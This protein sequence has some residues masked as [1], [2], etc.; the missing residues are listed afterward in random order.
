M[1]PP[2]R[3]RHG[4]TVD[5]EAPQRSQNPPGVTTAL[6]LTTPV[7]SRP[8]EPWPVISYQRP[9]ESVRGV[10][11]RRPTRSSRR[12]PRALPGARCR[13]P[14]HAAADVLLCALHVSPVPALEGVEPRQFVLNDLPLL[15][16]LGYRAQELGDLAATGD[17]HR[18]SLELLG[19]LRHTPPQPC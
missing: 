19:H 18:Q 12:I 1:Q 17:R 9:V 4:L 13:R 2:R 11:A 7:R 15:L 14:A 5:D 16:P 6:G 3:L 8:R 10:N